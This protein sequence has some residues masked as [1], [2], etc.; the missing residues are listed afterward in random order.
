[1]R[2]SLCRGAVLCVFV[3]PLLLASCEKDQA[4]FHEKE[5]LESELQ[6]ARAEI[7]A[8]DTQLSAL[9]Q[10]LPN[11]RAA[12]E[13]QIKAADRTNAELA[14]EM[15]DLNAR[16]ARLDAGLKKFRPVIEG[17]KAKYLP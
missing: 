5:A 11:A 16:L 9:G 13:S 3:L 7:T 4:V 6:K 8:F 2:I 15:V 17:Y 14:Q 1:M 10:T 12:L